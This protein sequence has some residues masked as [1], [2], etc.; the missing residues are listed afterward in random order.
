M[1]NPYSFIRWQDYCVLCWVVALIDKHI[2]VLIGGNYSDLSGVLNL[3]R[4]VK[5][6]LQTL[7]GVED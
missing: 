5:Q 3:H 6:L 7:Y 2:S 1:W 4:E